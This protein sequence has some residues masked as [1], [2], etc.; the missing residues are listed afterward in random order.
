MPEIWKEPIMKLVNLTPHSVTITTAG[1]RSLEVPASGQVARVA[2]E[3]TEA[4][5]IWAGRCNP[6]PLITQT[7]GEVVG[8]PA[9]EEG[10][11]FIVS[12]LVRAA[13]PDRYDIGS[14][15]DLVRDDAG[16]IIGCKALEVNR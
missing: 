16:R 11:F 12:A 13:C 15:A 1:G 2:A 10:K 7:F 4:G 14:P 6:V 3:A 5:E 8:L 9:P